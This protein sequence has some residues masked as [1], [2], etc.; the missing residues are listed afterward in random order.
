MWCTLIYGITLATISSTSSD[1]F[2]GQTLGAVTSRTQPISPGP[3]VLS[4]DYPEP[5]SR[6]LDGIP[7]PD[8]RWRPLKPLDPPKAPFPRLRPTRFLPDR[9]LESWFANGEI[10][11]PR[12]DV[13]PEDPLDVTWLWVNGSDP[14]WRKDMVEHRNKQGIASPDHHFRENNELVYS[15][16]SV[17]ASLPGRVRNLHLIVADKQFN[18]TTDLDLLPIDALP[19]LEAA[20]EALGDE[21]PS[22]AET[23]SGTLASLK[24]KVLGLRRGTPAASAAIQG[25]RL[26]AGHPSND[27]THFTELIHANNPEPS[28]QRGDSA[29]YKVS[30]KLR[31]W[32]DETWTVAQ[33]P[34]WLAFDRMDLGET[35][36]PF[37]H[38]HLDHIK[39]DV[40]TAA[41]IHVNS[42]P[43][44]RYA[45]HSE[46]FHLPTFASDGH[47]DVEH[48]DE[49]NWKETQWRKQSLPTFNS[50]AIESRIGFLWGLADAS[51]SLNDDFFLLKPHAIS[52]FQSPLYG[53]V[54][55]F[56]DNYYHYITP[57]LDKALVNDAGEVGSL[58][59]A[60]WLLSQR[61]PRRKR[62]YF[63]HAPKVVTRSM[64]HEA[65]IMFEEALTTS[66]RRRFRELPIGEGDIQMQWL[67][68]SLKV[69]RWR[70]A[71]LWTWIV[72]RVGSLPAWTDNYLGGKVDV[73]GEEARREIMDLFGLSEADE[74]ITRL[75]IHRGERWTLEEERMSA[76]FHNLGWEAPKETS[77]QW[78]E[79][80]LSFFFLFFL[81]ITIFP[82]KSLL[83]S[84]LNHICFLVRLGLTASMDG[85]MPR[86]IQPNHP[87]DTNERCIFD[88]ERCL[89]PFYTRNENTTA[90]EMFKRLAFAE[91][92]CGDC[93]SSALVT[94]SG[95]LGLSAFFPPPD[96]SYTNQEAI[97]RHVDYLPPPHLPMTATWQ[98]AD[99]SLANVMAET[100]LPGEK[101][102]LRM[103]TMKLLSRYQYLS[104][105]SRSLFHMLL[106][107]KHAGEVFESIDGRD[108]DGSILGLND[109]INTDYETTRDL[110]LAWFQKKW[111]MPNVWEKNWQPRD[112]RRAGYL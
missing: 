28:A 10:M 44:L 50:L 94:A 95:P 70:E 75:E 65:S 80:C 89:G 87:S 58:I 21:D 103:W 109:D 101:T 91:P 68:T 40:H 33:V 1:T 37:H 59:H 78:C 3:L 67:I 30:A 53:S 69:E 60:N 97:S 73:W 5:P 38:L 86:V 14:R 61:F 62:P 47:A 13:G 54:F 6:P 4:T 18:S 7:H 77:F 74:D 24:A 27:D 55:R 17:L 88:L 76:N 96:A 15:M 43:S 26:A 83:R 39:T 41:H 20:V 112:G 107:P 25:D 31:K 23:D 104:G 45:T 19:E 35:S 108:K 57:H 92:A 84:M 90:D 111:P 110:M 71:L 46:I 36:H 99:F 79:C 85:H 52:D 102:P 48:M 100:S 105:K 42:H 32:L 51:L 16:R 11:C 93:L 22:S 49:S 29:S 12:S 34:T 9:C 66:S 106:N 81:F 56:N 63:A 82:S 72:A 2:L 64:H 8:A 98:E